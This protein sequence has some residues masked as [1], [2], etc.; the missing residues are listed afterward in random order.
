MSDL[1]QTGTVRRWW[2]ERNYGFIESDD[3][4]CSD[5]HVHRK[6]LIGCWEPAE[7]TRVTFIV[8]YGRDGK[9]FARQVAPT[10]PVVVDPQ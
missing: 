6:G 5:V 2:A 1:Q 7:G 9:P 8:S 3:S 4:N 10:R